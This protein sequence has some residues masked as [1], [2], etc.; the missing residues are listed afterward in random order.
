ASVQRIKTTFGPSLHDANMLSPSPL[1]R[2]S[3]HQSNPDGVPSASPSLSIQ[4]MIVES[5]ESAFAQ[6]PTTMLPS[7]LTPDA[8]HRGKPSGASSTSM[9]PPSQIIAR[10]TEPSVLPL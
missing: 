3:K 6:E 2:A 5:L 7:S 8:V 10:R 1:T 4:R 9:K